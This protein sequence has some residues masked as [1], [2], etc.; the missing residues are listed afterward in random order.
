[1]TE[2]VGDRVEVEECGSVAGGPSDLR[3]QGSALCRGLHL[4]LPL[5][6]GA[7]LSFARRGDEAGVHAS[8]SLSGPEAELR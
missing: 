7:S 4:L 5:L 8:S 2:A 6:K 3:G 1:M